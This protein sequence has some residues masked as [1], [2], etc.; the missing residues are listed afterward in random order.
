MLCFVDRV[1]IVVV[2]AAIVVIV[3][4]VVRG[5]IYEKILNCLI[6]KQTTT[7]KNTK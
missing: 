2:V 5:V 6:G 4:M 3:V 1:V 7:L